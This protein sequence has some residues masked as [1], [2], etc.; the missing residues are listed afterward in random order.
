MKFTR[1]QLDRFTRADFDSI[2]DLVTTEE[3]EA[4]VEFLFPFV[5]ADITEAG[6]GETYAGPHDDAAFR[7][8]V[9]SDWL[10]QLD[11]SVKIA[12]LAL[13]KFDEGQA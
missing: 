1:E 7:D 12:K 10:G 5:L 6:F 8:E 9:V 2:D 3:R 13:V 11:G 4:I